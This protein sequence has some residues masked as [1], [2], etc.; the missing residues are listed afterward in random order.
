MS[1]RLQKLNQQQWELALQ[2]VN[3]AWRDAESPLTMFHPPKGLKHL[4]QEDWE[5]VCRCLWVLLQ[6]RE[7]SPLH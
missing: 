4:K 6:Q 1:Q 5:E 7:Q 2:V 3:Q